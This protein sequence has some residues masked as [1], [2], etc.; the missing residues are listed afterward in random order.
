[1]IQTLERQAIHP[2]YVNL[3]KHIYSNNF[4]FIQLHKDSTIFQPHKGVRQG[5]TILPKLFTA[6]LEEIFKKLVGNEKKSGIKVDGEY[7]SNLR[8][9]DDILL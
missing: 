6:C 9:A 7:L 8:S 2:T 4:S 3:M 5:N 1:M